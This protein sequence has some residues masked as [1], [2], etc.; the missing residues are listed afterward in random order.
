M[1]DN[2]ANVIPH[3]QNVIA[4]YANCEI[5]S[6]GEVVGWITLMEFC[7]TDLRKLLKERND[8][9]AFEKRKN[10][11]IGVKRGYDFM[12]KIGIQHFDMKPENVLIKNGTPKWTDFGLISEYSGRESYRKM[13]YA[14]RGSKFRN[15]D[16]LCKFQIKIDE[17]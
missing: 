17:S 4:H 16:Y 3:H 14:R 6:E 2:N 15:S 12:Y 9:L 13:G 11:A 1:E 8:H 7:E 5:K 10:I